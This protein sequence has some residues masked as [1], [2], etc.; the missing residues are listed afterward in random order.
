MASVFSLFSED[1]CIFRHTLIEQEKLLWQ[2]EAKDFYL[3]SSYLIPL[4]KLHW[5]LWN[6]LS[7]F[8]FILK[9]INILPD[10]GSRLQLKVDRT[11]LLHLSIANQVFFSHSPVLNGSFT[12]LNSDSQ[13][14]KTGPEIY[15]Y[16]NILSL[17]IIQLKTSKSLSIFQLTI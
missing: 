17:F 12:S 5:N 14:S 15:L 3:L 7:R 2:Q 4:Y 8:Y 1:L 10:L 6:F 13:C 16:D 11:S 9:H